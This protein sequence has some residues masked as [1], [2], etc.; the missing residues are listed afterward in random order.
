LAL[1]PALSVALLGVPIKNA[2]HVFIIPAGIGMVLGVMLIGRLVKY[3]TKIRLIAV[4]LIVAATALLLLGLS[5]ALHRSVHG[6]QIAAPADVSIIV[7]GLVLILGFMNAL[8]SAASQTILQEN[9]TEK[10]RGKV[11]GALNMMINIAATLPI[12]FAGILADLT[13]VNI[14]VSVLGILLLM[15]ATSQFWILRRQGKLA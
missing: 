9:T 14:V 4:G 15:F 2:S 10:T 11:F 7:G 13:S 6:H 12:F 1:A 5:V 3:Y 8:V